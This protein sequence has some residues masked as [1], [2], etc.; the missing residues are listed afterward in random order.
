MPGGIWCA[1]YRAELEGHDPRKQAPVP[2]TMERVLQI[3]DEDLGGSIA[4]LLSHGLEPRDLERLRRHM[5][6]DAAAA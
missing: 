5:T 4:W 6:P 2:G 3:I 1:T